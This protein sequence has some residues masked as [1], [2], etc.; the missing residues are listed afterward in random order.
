[1]PVYNYASPVRPS[2]VS[3]RIHL[4]FYA[5]CWG[6]P[7]WQ[8]S[9]FRIGHFVADSARWGF[10]LVHTGVGVCWQCVQDRLKSVL[11]VRARA[12]SWPVTVPNFL[13]AVAQACLIRQ[14]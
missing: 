9:F 8:V 12:A 4:S 11:T 10:C 7:V 3:L 5:A 2:I 13:G 1:M 14:N 6:R